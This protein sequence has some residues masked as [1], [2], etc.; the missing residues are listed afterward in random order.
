M[1]NVELEFD[2]MVEAY[3]DYFGEPGEVIEFQLDQ[4][5]QFGLFV[6]PYDEEGD[7][8]LVSIGL[9]N[10]LVDEYGPIELSFHVH[11]SD[12]S[13][14]SAAETFVEAI[15]DVVSTTER[16]EPNEIL[17]VAGWP[18]DRS[19]ILFY[20][21]VFGGIVYESE[22]GATDIPL[23]RLLPLLPEE[24]S[25]LAS[26]PREARRPVIFEAAP[27]FDAR[28]SAEPRF[29]VEKAV[30]NVWEQILDWHEEHDTFTWETVQSMPNPAADFEGL[31]EAL[32]CPVPPDL[33]ASWSIQNRSLYLH[34]YEYMDVER[35][36]Y[37]IE[38]GGDW[39]ADYLLPFAED[40]GGNM[41]CV[42]MREDRDYQ[43]YHFEV[44]E[45]NL[46]TRTYTFFAWLQAYREDLR[47]GRYTVDSEG[48]LD[49]KR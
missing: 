28:T 4:P 12:Q 21:H 30:E 48:F 42:D 26:M 16:L 19:A 43:I 45:G 31:E 39:L 44:D 6:S 1:S 35:V 38:G 2:R 46:A 32:G 18:D 40:S 37:R 7:G 22:E 41:I 5:G 11:Q 29:L 3:V 47:R 17:E 27:L 9:G 14:S 15:R 20:D 49:L 33:R 36:K 8:V 13:L 24:A 25:S 34:D 23:T 10:L